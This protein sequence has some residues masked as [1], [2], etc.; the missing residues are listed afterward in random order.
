MGGN[1]SLQNN[2]CD[3]LCLPVGCVQKLN[4]TSYH[5]ALPEL[6]DDELKLKL[7]F[8]LPEPE[9]VARVRLISEQKKP[10]QTE[11]SPDPTW[12]LVVVKDKT[13]AQSLCSS[14]PP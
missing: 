13:P 10:G 6:S 7:S 2:F 5:S 11:L 4:K 3:E 14:S 12:L 8:N 9:F 1:A